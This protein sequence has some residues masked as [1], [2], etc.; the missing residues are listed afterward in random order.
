MAALL[1]YF[2]V[3]PVIFIV[4]QAAIIDFYLKSLA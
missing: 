1:L 4:L 3:L 2:L